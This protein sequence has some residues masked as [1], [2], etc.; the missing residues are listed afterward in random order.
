MLEC[1]QLRRHET[2]NFTFGHATM[3]TVTVHLRSGE[4]LVINRRNRT[5]FVKCGMR[6]VRFVQIITLRLG[7]TVIVKC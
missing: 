2:R 7:Q 3:N 4:A 6:R 1:V 5:T